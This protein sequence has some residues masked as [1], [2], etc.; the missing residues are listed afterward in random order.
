[1]VMSAANKKEGE[2]TGGEKERGGPIPVIER[3]E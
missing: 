2:L 1:M 3:R